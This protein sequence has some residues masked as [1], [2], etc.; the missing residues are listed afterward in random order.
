MEQQ[1]CQ[2]KKPIRV[3]MPLGDGQ[4]LPRSVVIGLAMQ[5][6]DFDLVLITRPINPFSKRISE[7]ECRNELIRHVDKDSEYT[8]MI[9]SDVLLEGFHDFDYMI[10]FLEQNLEID[11]VA[12]NTKKGCEDESHVVIACTCFRTA[13]LINHKFERAETGTREGG[14]CCLGINQNMNI[15]YLSDKKIT[16]VS[17][18]VC[19]N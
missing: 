19:C 7:S 11:A 9:D 18:R 15:K 4:S 5:E 12:I 1:P 16:E 10:K 14:C 8:F 6:R 2:G 13:K 17:N 3:L